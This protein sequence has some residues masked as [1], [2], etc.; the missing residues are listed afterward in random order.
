MYK[1]FEIP[2]TTIGDNKKAS[3]NFFLEMQKL[4]KLSSIRDFDSL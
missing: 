4:I 2:K 3:H 1:F